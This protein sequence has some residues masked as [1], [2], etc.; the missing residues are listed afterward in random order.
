MGNLEL[1]KFLDLAKITKKTA[2]NYSDEKVAEVI[3]NL[4]FYDIVINFSK[5][6]DYF[7]EIIEILQNAEHN[8]FEEFEL[9]DGIYIDAL[10]DNIQNL[11]G[12]TQRADSFREKLINNCDRYEMQIIMDKIFKIFLK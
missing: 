7:Q 5:N 6:P 3:T 2:Q 12:N 11:L 8:S 9:Y 10:E 4:T 1:K